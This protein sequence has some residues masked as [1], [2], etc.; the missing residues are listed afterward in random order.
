[1]LD[2]RL[3][4]QLQ[5]IIEIDRLK[6]VLRRTPI[7]DGSRQENS[8]EHSWHLALMAL[9]L[10]EYADPAV[11]TGRVIRMV[12][13]HDLV[14]I[15]AGDTFCYDEEGVLSQAERERQA[16]QRVFGL[17]PENE[18][19][20]LRD[21]WREF[22]EGETAEARFAVA[23]DRLQPLLCNMQSQGGSWTIYSI[24]ADQVRSRMAPIARSSTRLADLVR[25]LISEAIAQ[26]ILHDPAN[27]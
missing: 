7:M 3:T 8:A 4:R 21:L 11:D 16:A 9:V 24:N 22:E 6:S 5:F 15:D 26:G 20:D 19:R 1:M 23:L 14:E 2:E 10:A 18:G 25:A 27:G 12:L 13:L 17:L